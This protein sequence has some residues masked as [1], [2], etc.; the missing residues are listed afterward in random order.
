[1]DYNDAL[2]LQLTLAAFAFSRSR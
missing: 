2:R 1:V